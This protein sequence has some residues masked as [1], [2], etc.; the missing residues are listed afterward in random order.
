MPRLCVITGA[1]R[2]LGRATARRLCADGLHVV[3]T[4]RNVAALEPLA[5]ELAARGHAFEACALDVDDDRSVQAMRDRLAARFDHLDVLINNAGVSLERYQSSLLDLPLDTLRATLE[6]NLFGVLRVTQ[7]LMPMLLRSEAGRIVNLASGLGQLAD[8]QAGVPAYRISKTAVN[9]VT[10]ILAVE[11]AD[12]AVKVNSVCP[13]WC[14]T[15][16]GGPDAPRSADEGADTIVWLATLPAD[17]PSGDFFRD[18]QPL[19]W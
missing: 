17:G 18:R 19:A 2:G 8:M 11:L 3:G 12:T 6:T 13:G 5:A 4:A 14:R 1:S 16:L 9:A 15:D 7:A 10:R